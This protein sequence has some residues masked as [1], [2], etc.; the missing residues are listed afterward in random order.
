[1]DILEFALEKERLS[2]EYY[3]QLAAKIENVGLHNIL[4]MLADEESNH[5]HVIKSMRS[6]IPAQLT[7]TNVL[8]EA[9]DIF[10]RIKKSVDQF[11]FSISEAQLYREARDK[12]QKSMEFYRQKAQ[13]VE[14]EAQ[15]KIFLKLADQEQ[16]HLKVID[17]ICEFVEAPQCY[18]ENAEFVHAADDF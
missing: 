15:K 13:E 12:E 7:K 11:D 16:K 14:D 2:R 4:Q 6:H 10:S 17:N 9:K 1:M 18:L 3:Q 8:R 5:C